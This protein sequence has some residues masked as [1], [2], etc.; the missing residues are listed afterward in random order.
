MGGGGGS[1]DTTTTVVPTMPEWAKPYWTGLAQ[2][3]R[4]AS[5]VPYQQYTGQRTA[6]FDPMEREAFGQVQAMGQAGPRPELGYAFGQTQQAGQV[7]ATPG[8]WGS[9]AYQQ[10]GN[11]F[12]ESVMAPGRER[13][14]E[15]YSRMMPESLRGV[16]MD[17]GSRGT[18]G[19]RANLEM[20][21][22]AKGIADQTARNLRE[23]EA[24]SRMASWDQAQKAFGE[25]E[26]R[27]QEGADIQLTAAA[28]AAELAQMQQAQA[29][30]R[31]SALQEAGISR[32]DMEQSIRN[33]AYE[34]FIE[35][36]DWDKQTL[37]W[38]AGLLSGTPY[39]Q[40]GK[41]SEQTENIPG[42]SP[43]SQVAGLGLAGLGAYSMFRNR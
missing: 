17:Y 22:V 10:F 43:I 27:R 18:L 5:R 14:M 31:I 11:P 38:L 19:G 13:I 21:G 4:K 29:M 37:N 7:G 9:Q 23:Y 20:A 41:V 26:T 8:Q 1:R 35:K 33:I 42:A 36:R 12:L 24:E 16:Q 40:T 32:R 6:D 39:A 15:N 30:Q 28:R 25:Q 2:A 34:D 3:G